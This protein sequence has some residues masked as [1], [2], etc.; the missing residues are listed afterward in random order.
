ML[1]TT[2]VLYQKYEGFCQLAD[3]QYFKRP[4]VLYLILPGAIPEYQLKTKD[5]TH[6][7]KR[8]M[9]DY[10]A[11]TFLTDFHQMAFSLA[12]RHMRNY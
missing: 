8:I 12:A 1:A 10:T 7:D 4:S 6:M 3:T 9:R 11:L 5:Y 2:F